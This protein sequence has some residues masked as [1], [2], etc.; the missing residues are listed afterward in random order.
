MAGG[1]RIETTEN[2]IN[3]SCG[4]DGPNYTT[5]GPPLFGGTIPFMYNHDQIFSVF[6]KLNIPPV[7]SH[8]FVC[9]PEN[10]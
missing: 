7:N 1:E 5:F 4:L 6:K 2:K 10:T 3:W 9:N 8:L